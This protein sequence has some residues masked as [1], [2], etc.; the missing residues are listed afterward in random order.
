MDDLL[1]FP[2][3]VAG[4]G[5]QGVFG[6]AGAGPLGT[7]RWDYVLGGIIFIITMFIFYFMNV[8]NCRNVM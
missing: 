5:A 1:F 4:P 3:N 7:P 6:G 8:S 2:T